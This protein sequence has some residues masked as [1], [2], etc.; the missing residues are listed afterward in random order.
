MVYGMIPYHI[1]VEQ[2]TFEKVCRLMKGMVSVGVLWYGTIH[3]KFIKLPSLV[4]RRQ[5]VA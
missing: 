2:H 3:R 4:S 1:S 5:G